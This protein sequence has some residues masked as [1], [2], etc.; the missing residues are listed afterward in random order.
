M[1]NELIEQLEKIIR[2]ENGYPLDVVGSHVVGATIV[3][4]EYEELT[5]QYLG[6]ED[7]AEAG[8]NLERMADDPEEAS[9]AYEHLKRALEHLKR[10]AADV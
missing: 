8:A 5:Q 1:K 2:N 10:N 6:L 7:V 9:R 3:R 4:D